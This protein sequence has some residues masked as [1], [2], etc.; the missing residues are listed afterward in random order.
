Q[1]VGSMRIGDKQLGA[2]DHKAAVAGRGTYA[3]PGGFKADTRFGA[4]ALHPQGGAFGNARQVPLLLRLGTVVD[5]RGTQKFR[6]IQANE[7]GIS[8][9][10]LFIHNE[11]LPERPPQAPVLLRPMRRQPALGT[12]FLRKAFGECA[13]AG[14][15]GGERERT[16]RQVFYR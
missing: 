3:N 8:D 14:S 16:G 9:S 11:I 4:V 10:H 1:G 2:V 5:D 13:T 7:W 6:T 15:V 12:D